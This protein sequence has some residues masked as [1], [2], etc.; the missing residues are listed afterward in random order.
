MQKSQLNRRAISLLLT[1][2]VV[3]VLLVLFLIGPKSAEAVTVS[4]TPSASSILVGGSITFDGSIVIQSNER[5]PISGVYLRIFSNAQCTTELTASPYSS[6]RTMSFVSATPTPGFGYGFGYGFDPNAGQG[7]SFGYGYGY[8]GGVTIAYRCTVDTT[9]WA[10]LRYY[11]RVDVDCGTHTYSSSAVSF[12]VA[13][14]PAPAGGG[15][16]EPTPTPTPTTTPTP[17]PTPTLIPTPTPT[18]TLIPTPTPT[19]TLTPTPTPTPPTPMRIDLSDVIDE[20]GMVQADIHYSTTDGMMEI[21]ISSGTIALTAD[22]KPLQSIEV[23]VVVV[24]EEIP[25]PPPGAYIIGYAY[26]L[27]PAGATFNPP[28]TLTLHY[29]PGLIPE[30]VVEAD[31]FIAYY[32]VATGQW[33]SLP[34]TVDTENNT[35]TAEVSHLT[36]FAILTPPVVVE[37]VPFNMWLVFGPI[38]GVLAVAGLALY[39]LIRRGLIWRRQTGMARYNRRT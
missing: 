28:I 12:T 10:T 24:S 38:L 27:G 1:V 18:P 5:I 11:A 4:V 33:V 14:A 15:A 26:D 25:P 9:S 17:T 37:V 34:S 7:Y 6:P 29:D 8:G 39:F 19:P 31:L 30:G 13:S 22:G 2:A 36:I 32:D 20:D 23:D 35:I 16:P 21:E 3:V